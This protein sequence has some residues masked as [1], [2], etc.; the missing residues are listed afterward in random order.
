MSERVRSKP[1][2]VRV[3]AAWLGVLAL[4]CSCAA[5]PTRVPQRPE[6]ALTSL[7]AGSV[8]SIEV[9]VLENRPRVTLVARDGDPRPAVGISFVVSE[10]PVASTALV[11]VLESRLKSAGFDVQSRAD[12]NAGHLTWRVVDGG[13]GAERFVETVAQAFASPIAAGQPDT[14][15]ARQ[16]LGSLDRYRLDDAA[17][18]DVL[19]CTGRLGLAP[20]EKVLDLGTSQGI[21]ALESHRKA[22][23]HSARTSIAAV[24]PASLC[25]DVVEAVEAEDG[26]M[27][28]P[29]PSDAWPRADVAHVYVATDLRPN[30]LRLTVAIRT[31]DPQAAT[32]A[33]ERLGREQSPLA[34]RLDTA[35][36]EWRA[37]E[38]SGVARPRGG[39]LSVTAERLQGDKGPV[40]DS[41]TAADALYRILRDELRAGAPATAASERILA[42]ADP[43][44]AA[45]RA[46][47]WALSSSAPGE[48]PRRVVALAVAP[49]QT[50]AAEVDPTATLLP[51][52]ERALAARASRPDPPE[53]EHRV[54]V[55]RGQGE[56]W[57]LVGSPC[58]PGDE[59]AQND[60]LSALAAIAAI[61]SLGPLD[62]VRLE[63]YVSPDGVGVLA[64][65]ALQGN[66]D[67]TS[68]GRRLGEAA[69]RAIGATEIEPADL[70][71]A[72]AKSLSL[73]ESA[74]GRSGAAFDAFTRAA[75]PERPSWLLPLSYHRSASASLAGVRERWRAVRQ[76]PLRIAVLA[77]ADEAQ[78]LAAVDAI[79]RWRAP[80]PGGAC[81]ASASSPPRPGS[82]RVEL[83]SQSPYAQG[84]VGVALPG[85]RDPGH[86]SA[87]LTALALDGPTGLLAERLRRSVGATGRVRILGGQRIA[88]L[89]VDVRAD[90]G[91]LPAAMKATHELLA[92]L[93]RGNMPQRH[94]QRATTELRH[95]WDE[96]EASLRHR[97]I[98][99]WQGRAPNARAAAG[100]EL[101]T[102]A[103]WS[104]WAKQHLPPARQIEIVGIPK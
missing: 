35:A 70:A 101:P 32:V 77:N 41:A 51:V 52:L 14:E 54:R 103:Q 85:N 94:W 45:E 53:L 39:C 64:H 65:G 72:R 34:S 61:E 91:S 87:E 16:R 12:R 79:Q 19:A 60:G 78:A 49:A 68:L 98:A 95:D 55:E 17:E 63:P 57:V 59:G 21:A 104:S 84:L 37:V 40:D 88:A 18:A 90:E 73:L 92:E 10:G 24:G 62:R 23:L 4:V 25:R 33:A 80:L 93:S 6:D 46:A 11:A 67:P 75:S 1:G 97:V 47:W 100:V 99:V 8:G 9:R 38:L 42:A 89:V 71:A 7:P 83:P 13:D 36:P 66:E 20:G 22:A 96:A 2:R 15:L 69:A 29:P 102:A 81:P 44:R 58:S 5:S 27:A 26:W 82:Q 48:L 3:V 30:H 50:P 28:G 86:A 76:G 74:I 43:A 56:M 31:P